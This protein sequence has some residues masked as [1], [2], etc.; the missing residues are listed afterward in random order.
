MEGI[1]GNHDLASAWKGIRSRKKAKPS[2]E[3]QD[4]DT[5]GMPR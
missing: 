1:K 5:A 3:V 4:S 2:E